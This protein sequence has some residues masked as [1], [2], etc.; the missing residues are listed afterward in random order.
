M[1]EIQQA[2]GEP[3]AFLSQPVTPEGIVEIDDHD[4]GSD[5]GDSTF[6]EVSSY[7]TSLISEVTNYRYE[8]GRRYSSDRFGNYVMPNDEQE[9]ER[10]D[11]CHEMFKRRLNGKLHLAPIGPSPQRVLDIGCGSGIWAIEMGDLYPS[12][13]IIGNDLS[14]IQPTWIPPN[15]RF[16]V[17]DAELEWTYRRDFDYIHVRWMAAGIKDWPRLLQQG[18]EHL[19]PGGWMEVQ[20][21]DIDIYSEDGSLKEDDPL[22]V[23]NKQCQ[24]AIALDGRTFSPGPHTR[25]RMEQAGFVNVREYPFKLPI[26]VWPKEKDH[27]DVGAF[28]YIQMDEGLEAMCLALYTR[29]LKWSREQTLIFLPEVRKSLNDPKIHSMYRL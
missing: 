8:N 11:I 28:N 10:L 29:Y 13:E 16:E 12:A 27:K 14:P 4:V 5:A 25:R 6:S 9:A 7:T 26:G 20:E 3:A 19:Q 2:P 22:R 1:A 18:Y 21:V 15:V 23:W 17:D 24:E